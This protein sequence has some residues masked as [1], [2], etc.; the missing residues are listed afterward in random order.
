MIEAKTVKPLAKIL[1]N[2]HIL[3]IV[4][5][6]YHGQSEKSIKELWIILMKTLD[7]GRKTGK[8]YT[9]CIQALSRVVEGTARWNPATW[10]YQGAKSG[11]N[12]RWGFDIH[13]HRIRCA[14]FLF[15]W[16][17]EENW[18]FPAAL[19]PRCFTTASLKYTK[20]SIASCCLP[21]DKI[22]RRLSANFLLQAHLDELFE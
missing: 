11:G 4:E 14:V 12:E 5:L 21:R 3:C 9:N 8:I 1:Q 22:S 18:R 13:A 17:F 19:L 6:W 10:I 7:I 2:N 15:W 20:Y 16:T